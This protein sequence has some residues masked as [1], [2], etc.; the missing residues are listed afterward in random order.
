MFENQSWLLDL[1]YDA[2]AV[3]AN[4]TPFQGMNVGS[5]SHQGPATNL[6][7]TVEEII[8]ILLGGT[9]P[10]NWSVGARSRRRI[11]VTA[12]EGVLTNNIFSLST[13]QMNVLNLF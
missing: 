13:G 5:F 9:A 12:K 8:L 1:I 10:L 2:F 7:K 6:R 3:E 11:G 4:F